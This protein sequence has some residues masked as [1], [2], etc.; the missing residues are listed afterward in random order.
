VISL[1]V[2]VAETVAS[3]DVRLD[4]VRLSRATVGS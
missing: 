1:I 4:R 2:P 3:D